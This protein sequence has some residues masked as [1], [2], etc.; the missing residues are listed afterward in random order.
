MRKL[1]ATLSKNLGEIELRIHNHVE[2]GEAYYKKLKFE[3]KKNILGYFEF[4]SKKN[5]EEITK[6][7]RKKHSRE[8]SPLLKSYD[9]KTFYAV[10]Y[11]GHR[12]YEIKENIIKFLSK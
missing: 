11:P 9:G 8:A 10:R 3:N 5:A 1:S 7:F 2:N 4:N 6:E 12:E